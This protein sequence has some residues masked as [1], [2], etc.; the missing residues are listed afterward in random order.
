MIKASGLRKHILS[1]MLFC[2]FSCLSNCATRGIKYVSTQ[3]LLR[4]DVMRTASGRSK[5]YVGTHFGAVGDLPFYASCSVFFDGDSHFGAVFRQQVFY[6]FRPLQ[7]TEVA[8]VEI[9]F[10]A[11]IVNL[12]EFL[13]AVEIEV[14]DR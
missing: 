6:Q 1:Q 11:H 7:E 5:V 14:V 4:R 10:V 13:D 2:S 8:A 12:I 9:I 3:T